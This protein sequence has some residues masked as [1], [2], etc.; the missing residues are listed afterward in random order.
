MQEAS[1]SLPAP[2]AEAPSQPAVIRSE[3]LAVA[4][5]EAVQSPEA[6][7]KPTLWQEMQSTAK[8]MINQ[9]VSEVKR[10]I[11]EAGGDQTKIE[12]ILKDPKNRALVTIDQI[13]SLKSGDKVSIP[14]DQ[15]VNILDKDGWECT[16]V[17]ISNVVGESFQVIVVDRNNK[18]PHLL[19]EP[20]SKQVLEQ[21]HLLQRLLPQLGAFPESQGK[22][23]QL[24]LES[25][26]S[27]KEPATLPENSEKMLLEAAQ[28]A[29]ILTTNDIKILL[30]R[31][32]QHEK[33]GLD[34]T[35]SDIA[36]ISNTNERLDNEMIR[37]L[38]PF[39]DRGIVIT[40]PQQISDLLEGL[41]VGVTQLS[42]MRNQSAIEATQLKL[43]INANEKNI[44]KIIKI[45]GKDVKLTTEMYRQWQIDMVK[46]EELSTASLELIEIYKKDGPTN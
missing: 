7:R 4:P 42:E 24:Y 23:I 16:V 31:V 21:A 15:Q 19:N 38:K 28:S 33:A 12:A 46:S 27:G 3:V 22:I 30:E 1:A 29:G 14:A 35:A 44:G 36:K 37:L 9:A 34:A 6:Q 13:R 32:L 18:A 25:V 40:D 26:K 41:G 17:G 20:V 10:Q 11:D 45:E 39:I 2:A 8:V 43:L 5:A